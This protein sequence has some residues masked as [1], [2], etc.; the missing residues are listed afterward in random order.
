MEKALKIFNST[1][2]IES[3]RY[4]VTWPWKGEFQDLPEN[5]ELA[6]GRLTSLVHK[7]QRNSELLHKY[8]EII[9][10]QC[11]KEIIEKVQR[12]HVETGIKHYIPYYAVIDLTKSTTKVRIVYDASAK[13]QPKN[14]SLNKCLHRGPVMLHDCC[15]LLMRFRLSNRSRYWEEV[16]QVGLHEKDLDAKRFF[17]GNGCK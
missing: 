2:K 14:S 11:N 6:Y 10:D 4:Q 17:L 8:D 16:L 5:R 7:L 1:L 15:G 12:S 3:N 13:S 9:Q